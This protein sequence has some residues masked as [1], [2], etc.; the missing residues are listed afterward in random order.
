MSDARPET[1]RMPGNT[2][3]ECNAMLDA[4]TETVE[5]QAQAEAWG[6]Q[7]VCVLHGGAALR[8]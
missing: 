4:A 6:L 2:C 8:R 7:R 3:P 5:G 1:Y